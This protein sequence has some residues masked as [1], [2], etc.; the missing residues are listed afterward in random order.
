M[1]GPARNGKARHCRVACLA[2][3]GKGH[4]GSGCRDPFLRCGRGC[5]TPSRQ[6]HLDGERFVKVTRSHRSVD[7]VS[8]GAGLLGWRAALASGSN[9]G[10][11]GWPAGVG[12][13][14]GWVV[15]KQGVCSRS[16]PGG[17][18]SPTQHTRPIGYTFDAKTDERL[19]PQGYSFRG[20][21]ADW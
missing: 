3:L 16:G 12:K 1:D 4:W 8:K 10:S 19:P 5:T 14:G 21:R 2:A 6:Y 13:Q 20:G 18:S 15:A 11:H 9:L 17:G 7:V